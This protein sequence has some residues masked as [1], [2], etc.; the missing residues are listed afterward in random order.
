MTM[1]LLLMGWCM[2]AQ[3]ASTNLHCTTTIPKHLFRLLVVDSQPQRLSAVASSH[4]LHER[5][6]QRF[7]AMGRCTLYSSTL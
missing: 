5:A 7:D 2:R 6:D 1:L 3:H 4:Q